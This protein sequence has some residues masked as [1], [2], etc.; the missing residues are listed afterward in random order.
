MFGKDKEDDKQK[1]TYLIG[2]FSKATVFVGH[3]FVWDTSI[4]PSEFE[5]PVHDV[6]LKDQTYRFWN[7]DP[8][9]H[10]D[11]AKRPNTIVFAGDLSGQMIKIDEKGLTAEHIPAL[12]R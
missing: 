11:L 8:K 3:G 5:K 2:D 1:I 6:S 10:K 4:L 12:E 9:F 7:A